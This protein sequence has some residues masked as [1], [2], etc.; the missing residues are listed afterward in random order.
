[1]LPE[2]QPNQ[3]PSTSSVHWESLMGMKMVHSDLKRPLPDAEFAKIAC[4]TAGLES[5]ASGMGSTVSP[6]S[7]VAT[8][9]WASG[10]IN[11]AEAQGYV[12]GDPAGTFRPEDHIT[13][14]EVVTVLMRILGYND[15]LAGTWPSDYIAKAA[16]LG[17]LDDVTFVADNA[18]ARGTVAIMTATVLDE[19]T[20]EY[21]A[22]DNIFELT[23]TTLL[24]DNFESSGTDTDTPAFVY[25]LDLS[26]GEQAI[27]IIDPS[28]DPSDA[29]DAAQIKSNIDSCTF[30]SMMLTDNCVIS[31]ATSILGVNNRFV[32]YI[33]NDDG[34]IT[35]IKVRDDE[36]Y[37]VITGID[38]GDIKR[39]DNN[40]I[41][42]D[43][44]KSYDI[45]DDFGKYSSSYPA[46]IYTASTYT[47]GP[48]SYTRLANSGFLGS[49]RTAV[50][51]GGKATGGYQSA[52]NGDYLDD[53]LEG[54]LLSVESV[55][56]VLNDDGE[57]VFVN[58]T[59]WPT[60]VGSTLDSVNNVGIVEKVNVKTGKVSLK[61][62]GSFTFDVDDVDNQVI[63]RNGALAS[64]NELA[65]N[66]MV[67][68][69]NKYGTELVVAMSVTATG[70]FNNY[71][72]T[73]FLGTNMAKE[74]TVG[75]KTYDVIKGGGLISTDD[76]DT[77]EKITQSGKIIDDFDDI[78][79][80]DVTVWLS[81]S[82]SIA[83]IASTAT[84][85]SGKIY[86]VINDDDVSTL[87]DGSITNAIEVLKADST[88]AT[89]APDE[90]SEIYD[91]SNWVGLDED[92][93]GTGNKVLK[94]GDFV[95]LN[96][97][98]DGYIN[99]IS[100]NDDIDNVFG[101][102]SA[103]GNEDES[104][105]TADGD[106]YDATDLIV[107]SLSEDS[108]GDF[109]IIKLSDFLDQIDGSVAKDVNDGLEGYSTF[110]YAKSAE[111][112]YAVVASSTLTSSTDRVAMVYSKAHDATDS[113]VYLMTTGNPVKYYI[114]DEASDWKDDTV[115]VYT[116]SGDKVKLS[117]PDNIA[118]DW[119]VVTAKE[120]DDISGKIIKIG[121]ASYYVDSDTLY[122]NNESDNDD[123]EVIELSDLAEGDT[124]NIYSDG[125]G[126]I[127]AVEIVDA[128]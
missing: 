126:A 105:V 5:V 7:D 72:D 11:V 98:S 17:D 29:T 13:Q 21:A 53:Y 44:S 28:L 99:R 124:V 24:A 108:D 41:K 114:D 83:A 26:D 92:D 36:N 88:F 25:D 76:A 38:P 56:L 51:I 125:K 45:A 49:D 122:F 90:D 27:R 82:M 67:W 3:L 73:V 15:N 39:V 87:V 120:I 18:A 119:N 47:A 110:Y 104:V 109:Q 95:E 89:Y 128:D 54:V 65:E 10:W 107:F 85:T 8:D 112:K 14:A 127:E 46:A 48:V 52:S 68:D 97:T 61:N 1:M 81:P 22:S 80:E 84:V 62:G 55:S 70:T 42:V 37:K 35:Y 63:L 2:N 96:L 79:G 74:V 60:A 64:L 86:G 121:T 71:E 9:H 59:C 115:A 93:I 100:A 20:V 118:N 6:F 57:I 40:T 12:K 77:F 111:M 32:D 43:D 30:T 34:D 33:T 50:S 69:L 103:Y 117:D 16:N 123:P 58:F 101:F 31:G 75:D 102:T 113:F 19:Y 91:G 78:L 106:D 116:V 66:D 23:N 4:I 94:K